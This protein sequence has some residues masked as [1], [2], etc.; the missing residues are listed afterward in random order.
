MNPYSTYRIIQLSDTDI[1]LERSPLRASRDK[2]YHTVLQGETIQSIAYKYYGDSGK[3]ADI[4]DM[5]NILFPFEELKP[6][7]QLLIPL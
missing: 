7:M 3:W 2:I 4:C 1:F 6:D 5:N